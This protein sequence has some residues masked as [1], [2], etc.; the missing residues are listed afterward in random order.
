M[1]CDWAATC[2]NPKATYSE[3]TDMKPHTIDSSI[4]RPDLREALYDLSDLS[5]TRNPQR[6][7]FM[8]RFRAFLDKEKPQPSAQ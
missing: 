1:T 6:E 2:G 5:S 4:M 8:K 3:T 7:R